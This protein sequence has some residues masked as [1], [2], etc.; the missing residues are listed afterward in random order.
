MALMPSNASATQCS[1]SSSTE[2][3]LRSVSIW[4][5]CMECGEFRLKQTR[6]QATAF[7]SAGI[8]GT[9]AGGGGAQGGGIVTGRLNA[10]QN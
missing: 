2:L 3:H 4:W 9:V 1:S 8:E 10:E 5:Q 6:H 7:C